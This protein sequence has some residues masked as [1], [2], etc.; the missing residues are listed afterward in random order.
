MIQSEVRSLV[1]KRIK[2]KN[3]KEAKAFIEKAES[4]NQLGLAYLSA[5]DYLGI[6]AF[7]R[8][9]IGDRIINSRFGLYEEILTSEGHD[10]IANE[11]AILESEIYEI[12]SGQQQESNK[13]WERLENLK[14]QLKIAKHLLE[15][16][17]KWIE[18]GQ[19]IDD[20]SRIGVSKRK[21][22]IDAPFEKLYQQTIN[23][24]IDELDLDYSMAKSIIDYDIRQRKKT[25]VS[26]K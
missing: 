1:M 6:N 7:D 4:K 2:W 19:Y 17:Y 11:I 21:N 15:E 24:L 23:Y 16:S 26:K 8:R 12:E 20:L 9:K 18:Y 3:K 13:W 10:A 22:E 5:C 25:I 14:K